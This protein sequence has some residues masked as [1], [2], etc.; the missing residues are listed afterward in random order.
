MVCLA[1]CGEGG[2]PAPVPGE[3]PPL[4]GERLEQG[5]EIWLGTCGN[6]H[7]RG[8]AGAPLIGDTAAWA[9]RIVQEPAV[10]HAHAIDGYVGPDGT[11]MPARGGNPS[12]TDAQVRAAVDYMVAASQPPQ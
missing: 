8:V 9:P 12:L 4:T 7:A 5:R 10:L 3:A 6:C 2:P 1:A 11:M